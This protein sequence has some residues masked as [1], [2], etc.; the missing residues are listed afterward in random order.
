VSFSLTLAVLDWSYLA[1]DYPSVNQN[2][3]LALTYLLGL[4]AYGF[5]FM[6]CKLHCSQLSAWT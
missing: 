4:Q 2:P 1:S 6:P 3:W 5:D